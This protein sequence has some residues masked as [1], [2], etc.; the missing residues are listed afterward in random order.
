MYFT[1]KH[2]LKREVKTRGEPSTKEAALFFKLL[3]YQVINSQML[4]NE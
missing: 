2:H 3:I 4:D 1:W